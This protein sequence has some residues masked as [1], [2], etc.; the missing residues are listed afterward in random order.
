MQWFGMLKHL[1]HRIGEVNTCLSLVP[2]CNQ[3]IM[4]PIVPVAVVEKLPS[5]PSKRSS[6]RS[7]CRNQPE[8]EMQPTEDRAG[9]RAGRRLHLLAV[10]LAR[11]RRF[12]MAVPQSLRGAGLREGADQ[13]LIDSIARSRA[14]GRG[15]RLDLVRLD[16]YPTWT[17]TSVRRV[18]NQSQNS[19]LASG[20]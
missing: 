13:V 7:C 3:Q 16:Q 8:L 14:S 2:H 6:P 17:K 15:V 11:R 10:H 12:A 20:G 1:C 9:E 5:P 19:Q 4:P 18:Q